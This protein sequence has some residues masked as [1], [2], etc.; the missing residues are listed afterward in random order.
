LTQGCPQSSVCEDGD[1][2]GDEVDGE[3]GDESEEGDEVED[4]EGDESEEGDEV[5]GEE[6][7]EAAADEGSAEDESDNSEDGYKSNIGGK[8]EDDGVPKVP[9][10]EA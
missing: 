2:E 9:P 1:E 3:D 10:L 8:A 4:E 6:S 7:D 5:E